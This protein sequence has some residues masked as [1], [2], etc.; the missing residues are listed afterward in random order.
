MAVHNASTLQGAFLKHRHHSKV[1]VTLYFV[2]GIEERT[3]GCGTPVSLVSYCRPGMTLPT[4][5]TALME[6]RLFTPRQS[7]HI[8]RRICMKISMVD[9]DKIG[10]GGPW[11]A[12]VTNQNTSRTYRVRG[13]TCELP[14]CYCDAVIIC[15]VS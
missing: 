2:N 1:D 6:T 11:E 8:N 10:R 3:G 14:N 15:E 13:A 9:A 5:G 7:E 4:H 12:T